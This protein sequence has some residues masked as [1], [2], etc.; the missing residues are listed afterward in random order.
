MFLIYYVKIKSDKQINQQPI[1]DT[2]QLRFYVCRWR[3]V[4]DD[5][6]KYNFRSAHAGSLDSAGRQVL[7]KHF[8]AAG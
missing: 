1:P 7:G 8:A 3:V 2:L 6:G 5:E 4:A